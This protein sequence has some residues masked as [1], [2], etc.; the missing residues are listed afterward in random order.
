M[1]KK[2]ICPHCDGMKVD[3]DNTSEKCPDC[4][5]SGYVEVH[6]VKGVK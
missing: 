3:P 4:N 1:E 6:E 2:A 5:G